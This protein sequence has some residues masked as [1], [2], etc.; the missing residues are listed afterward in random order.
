VA[1]KYRSYESFKARWFW[2]RLAHHHQTRLPRSD[3]QFTGQNMRAFLRRAGI[4]VKEYQDWWGG[5]I[6]EFQLQNP[7]WPL[8]AWAGLTLE[9]LRPPTTEIAHEPPKGLDWE[10]EMAS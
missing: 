5:R 4:S 8:R 10:E 3:A 2:E 1:V 6:K 7:D 9:H